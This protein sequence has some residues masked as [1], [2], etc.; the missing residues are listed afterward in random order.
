M[1]TTISITET[2]STCSPGEGR[3]TH[4]RLLAAALL[5]KALVRGR[6][7]KKKPDTQIKFRRQTGLRQSLSVRDFTASH[8]SLLTGAVRSCSSHKAAMQGNSATARILLCYPSDILLLK[9]SA[10]EIQRTITSSLLFM[11]TDLFSSLQPDLIPRAHAPHSSS[12]PRTGF[13][14]SVLWWHEGCD[15]PC[16]QAGRA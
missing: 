1:S 7:K 4:A 5:P 3:L 9:G 15:W 11:Q 6:W 2:I 16:R 8:S 10:L 14:F 12:G 13:A